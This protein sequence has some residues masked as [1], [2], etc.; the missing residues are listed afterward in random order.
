MF[1]FSPTF[2]RSQ[3]VEYMKEFFQ[4]TYKV[5]KK[6]EKLAAAEESGCGLEGEVLTRRIMTLSCLGVGYS[7]FNKGIM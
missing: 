4:L 2:V 5:E 1:L 3:F 7:N 6:E